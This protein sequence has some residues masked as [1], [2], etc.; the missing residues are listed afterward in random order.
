MWVTAHAQTLLSTCLQAGESFIT[1]HVSFLLQCD[2][3]HKRTWRQ[4][5]ESSKIWGRLKLGCSGNRVFPGQEHHHT[6][7]G[8]TGQ[9]NGKGDEAQ[10]QTS[11]QTPCAACKQ[12][13]HT[14]C[15]KQL[16]ILQ[17]CKDLP[18]LF[19]RRQKPPLLFLVLAKGWIWMHQ[20]NKE[21]RPGVSQAH[22]A[23]EPVIKSKAGKCLALSCACMRVSE[24]SSSQQQQWARLSSSPAALLHRGCSNAKPV[25]GDRGYFI[26]RYP[27]CCTTDNP[28]TEDIFLFWEVHKQQYGSQSQMISQ[29]QL[30]SSNLSLRTVKQGL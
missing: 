15:S 4:K 19:E 1:L 14:C 18:R 23:E 5:I 30:Y 28:D 24:E 26:S 7:V 2:G 17:M 13:W 8:T 11:R 29:E 21:E 27:K 10:C 6:L 20:K 9:M 16:Q 25:S 22:S 3:E 12:L